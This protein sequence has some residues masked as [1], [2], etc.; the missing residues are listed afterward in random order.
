MLGLPHNKIAF[1]IHLTLSFSLLCCS[2]PY[3]FPDIFQLSFAA[4]STTIV[5]GCVAMRLKF[6]VYILYSLIAVIFYSFVAH[7]LFDTSGWLNQMVRVY[8]CSSRSTKSFSIAVLGHDLSIFIISIAIFRGLMI[9]PEVQVCI[10]LGVLMD[11]LP[12]HF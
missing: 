3:M 4:T 12:Q 1:F 6:F 7:W 2:L 8:I 9:S 10:Y 11:S 5:S